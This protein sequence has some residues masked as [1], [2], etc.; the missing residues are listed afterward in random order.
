MHA[1]RNVMVVVCGLVVAV[2]CAVNG[3]A[4]ESKGENYSAGKTPAQLFSSDCTGSGCHSAPQGLAK[5]R[6]S[7]ELS[8]FLREHYT[9][10]R[11]SAD[12]LAKYLNSLSRRGVR[13]RH[14]QSS[15][16]PTATPR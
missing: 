7:G 2:L 3:H 5:G 14:G 10:S 1:L 9:N 13:I 11:Q 15:R 4:Q 16:K 12:A 8:N 6:G